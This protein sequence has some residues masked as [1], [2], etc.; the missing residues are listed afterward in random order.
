[1]AENK[2]VSKL[3]GNAV[4]KTFDGNGEPARFYHAAGFPIEGYSPTPNSSNGKTT[5][6]ADIADTFRWLTIRAKK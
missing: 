5:E 2:T 1:M 6:N 4:W 3:P